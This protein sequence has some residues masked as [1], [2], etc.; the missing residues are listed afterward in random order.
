MFPFLVGI[1]YLLLLPLSDPGPAPYIWKP[2]PPPPGTEP[3]PKP[4]VMGGESNGDPPKNIPP[5]PPPPRPI[6]AA[7]AGPLILDG[8]MPGKVLPTA[9]PQVRGLPGK[10]GRNPPTPPMSALG[11]PVDVRICLS[12]VI[13]A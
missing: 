12:S 1:S 8:G 9:G 7:E 5:P 11:L 6:A 13:G 3:R 4:G 10:P 2:T